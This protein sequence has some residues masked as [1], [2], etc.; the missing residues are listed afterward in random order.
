MLCKKCGTQLAET[1]V[2]CPQCG[3]KN[4]TGAQPSETA[5]H[6]RAKKRGKRAGRA[7]ATTVLVS[8]L[9]V[10]ALGITIAWLV[11]GKA[12]WLLVGEALGI[13]TADTAEAA[14]P[15]S[16]TA[17]GIIGYLDAE[18]NV[19]FLDGATVTTFSGPVD[20]GHTT[21]DHSKY[22]V[23]YK[24]NRLVV[25]T[26]S[27]DAG[28]LIAEDASAI[29][30]CTD[31]GVFYRTNSDTQRYYV[32]SEKKNI[33]LGTATY[34]ALEFSNSGTA[35]AALSGDWTLYLYAEGD[36]AFRNLGTVPANTRICCVADDG[37]NVIWSVPGENSIS[38]Y[39]LKDGVPE[40]I[41]EFATEDFVGSVYADFFNNGDSY[42]V[43]YPR[44]S[45]K[46]LLGYKD[47][48]KT[49]AMPGVMTFAAIRNAEGK[50]IDSDDD[51]LQELYLSVFSGDEFDPATVY[52]LT[53]DGELTYIDNAI[54][55]GISATYTLAGGY[56]YY[57][58][59]NSN[60]MRT[61]LEAPAATELVA[62]DIDFMYISPT[63]K[64][65]Y[66]KKSDKL[67]VCSG[68]DN[69][70]QL[71]E[72]TSNFGNNCSLYITDQDD[73]VY[74]LEFTHLNM[75]IGYRYTVGG[76]PEEISQSVAS[77]DTGDQEYVS[78]DTPR[79]AVYQFSTEDPWDDYADYITLVDGKFQTVLPQVLIGL[80]F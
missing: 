34:E 80:G 24:D 9:L 69:T 20:Q 63:G 45:S 18:R 62:A 10:L 17:V 12:A 55:N 79:I 78:A 65:I 47:E 59:A 32:F 39:M 36:D 44:Y 28:E 15:V 70:F 53:L 16:Y 25:Y 3:A 7:K 67:Y 1:D 22:L 74:W 48:V 35:L 11:T 52:R 30:R 19:H 72:I 68:T 77:I 66:I 73:V 13:G 64:Y 75:G 42:F 29:L 26:G 76:E 27:D 46:F 6:S 38:V 5:P 71:E 50:C 60:L 41:G 57:M 43:Y 14:D 4:R 21:P 54:R 56:L 33:D 8:L 49:L 23:L 37:S 61:S 2:F 58:D 51:S 31:K 40:C